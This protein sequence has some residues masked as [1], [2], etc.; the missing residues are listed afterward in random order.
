MR[1]L[2]KKCIFNRKLNVNTFSKSRE[3][4]ETKQENVNSSKVR[5][6]SLPSIHYETESN[7]YQISIL[8][9]LSR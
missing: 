4:R 5:C 1:N 2:K 7:K 8:Y 9:K 3:V 6:D